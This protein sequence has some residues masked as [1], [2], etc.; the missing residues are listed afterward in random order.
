MGYYHNG[1][2]RNPNVLEF[3]KAAH[4]HQMFAQAQSL[5]RSA[6]TF[7]PAQGEAGKIYKVVACV[8]ELRSI[9]RLPEVSYSRVQRWNPG[10]GPLKPSCRLYTSWFRQP[11]CC[12][13]LPRGGRCRELHLCRF[14]RSRAWIGLR[15]HVILLVQ[16]SA[17]CCADGSFFHLE[18]SCWRA[19]LQ[20]W[21]GF[22]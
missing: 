6:R 22:L 10:C 20:E 18:G 1:N 5:T 4:P 16:T 12:S 17:A 13:E 11:L 2:T 8:N 14:S 19:W 9:T 15:R 3:C 7:F 21:G